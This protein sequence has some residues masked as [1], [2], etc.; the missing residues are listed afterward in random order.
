MCRM[1]YGIIQFKGVFQVIKICKTAPNNLSDLQRRIKSE[2]PNCSIPVTSLKLE[3]SSVMM[4]DA[5]KK[6]VDATS[7]KKGYILDM[8]A[9]CQVRHKGLRETNLENTWLYPV[10]AKLN[11]DLEKLALFVCKQRNKRAIVFIL[12]RGKAPEYDTFD[13]FGDAVHDAYMRIN[14][15]SNSDWDGLHIL[16]A[17][18]TDGSCKLIREEREC[19]RSNLYLFDLMSSFVSGSS[20]IKR[21]IPSSCFQPL[22]L[23]GS[24]L[25]NVYVCVLPDSNCHF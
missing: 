10:G 8:G 17:E 19:F 11:E 1:C 3:E 7:F 9:N 20:L 4:Y 23:M 15:F 12:R 21:Q 16:Y 2:F 24:I 14:E 22:Q 6:Y 13:T 18:V 25:E 5:F